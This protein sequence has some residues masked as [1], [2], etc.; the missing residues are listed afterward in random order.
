MGIRGFIDKVFLLAA[1]KRF[2]LNMTI[3][4]L[5]NF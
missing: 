1:I 4:V 2:N 5:I 3:F